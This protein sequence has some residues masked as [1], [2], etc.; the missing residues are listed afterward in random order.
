MIEG[1]R[2]KVYRRDAS[3]L[4]FPIF[5]E[6]MCRG[7]GKYL[8]ER[9][10]WEKEERLKTFFSLVGSVWAAKNITPVPSR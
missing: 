10:E 6:W 2:R 3:F 7:N 1:N 9:K 5:D 8:C 4:K